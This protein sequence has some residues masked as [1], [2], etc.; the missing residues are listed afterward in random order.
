MRPVKASLNRP[1]PGSEQG[2]HSQES[3]SDSE[4]G[5]KNNIP[6]RKQIVL[7]LLMSKDRPTIGYL[8]HLN[9]KN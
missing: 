7:S 1:A 6:V 8:I 4:L 2:V 5:I 9:G 3:R